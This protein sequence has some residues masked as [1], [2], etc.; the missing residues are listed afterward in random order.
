MECENVRVVIN[1]EYEFSGT[2]VHH[3][4]RFFLCILPG[5][6]QKA[7]IAAETILLD[8][9]DQSLWIVAKIIGKKAVAAALGVPFLPIPSGAGKNA[10]K[11][12]G[13]YKEKVYESSQVTW[14]LNFPDIIAISLWGSIVKIEFDNDEYGYASCNLH[15]SSEYSARLWCNALNDHLKRPALPASTE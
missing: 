11:I 10:K 2:L 7:A 8:D 5:T 4:D 15:F 9:L 6:S 3:K 14:E 1:Q 13:D 12:S